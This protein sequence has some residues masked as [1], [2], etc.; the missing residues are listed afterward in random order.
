M[1]P[2]KPNT[3]SAATTIRRRRKCE[4]SRAGFLSSGGSS[5]ENGRP[6]LTNSR[7]MRSDLGLRAPR[8][9]RP[10]QED[11]HH[12]PEQS[13]DQGSDGV[14]PARDRSPPDNA[15]QQHERG[16]KKQQNRDLCRLLLMRKAK[17]ATAEL[18]HGLR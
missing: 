8:S 2:A 7:R 1:S 9:L 10:L 16:T 18:F 14:G 15:H 6:R 12:G 11:R 5:A 3:I 13:S 17:H 4:S